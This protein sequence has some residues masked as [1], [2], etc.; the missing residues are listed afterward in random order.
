[1][2]A[3]FFL[4]QHVPTISAEADDASS[5][6]WRQLEVFTYNNQLHLRIGAVNAENDGA[7]RYTVVLTKTA[8]HALIEAVQD[9]IDRLVGAHSG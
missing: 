7:K 2:G 5:D 8:A 3:L 1:M 4:D 6:P 9:G